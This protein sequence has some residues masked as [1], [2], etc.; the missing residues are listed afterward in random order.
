MRGTVTFGE[1]NRAPGSEPYST[2][3]DLWEDYDSSR[4]R[5]MAHMST[6]V[7]LPNGK[8]AGLLISGIQRETWH[9]NEGKLRI[10]EHRQV[11]EVVPIP[12]TD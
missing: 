5:C 11:W 9:D 4:R 7:I 6:P 12:S 10:K 2:V 1:M 3:V 8:R